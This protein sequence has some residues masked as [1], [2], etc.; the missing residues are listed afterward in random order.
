[1]SVGVAEHGVFVDRQLMYG[2]APSDLV[3]HTKAVLSQWGFRH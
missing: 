1:M 3:M 2:F